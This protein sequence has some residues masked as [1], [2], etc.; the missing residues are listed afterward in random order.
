MRGRSDA[1]APVIGRL[2]GEIDESVA[3]LAD[4]AFRMAAAKLQSEMMTVFVAEHAT[5]EGDHRGIDE[6][7]ALLA[8]AVGD[9][10]EELCAALEALDG[11]LRAV[12]RTRRRSGASS[13]SSAR[14]RSTGEAARATDAD[15]VQTL[16]QSIGEQVGEAQ[17]EI[18]DFEQVGVLARRRDERIE[19]DVR[20]AAARVRAAVAALAA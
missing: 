3:L 4:M 5:G 17:E 7:P 15:D 12:G 16:I 2:S 11:H 9:A 14:W 18:T 10:V 1:A 20:D 8:A 19:R 6:Q 13:T